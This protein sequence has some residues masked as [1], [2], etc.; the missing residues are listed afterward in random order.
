[1]LPQLAARVEE[2]LTGAYSALLQQLHERFPSD[3]QLDSFAIVYSEYFA[4]AFDT[5]D[6]DKR[7]DTVIELYGVERKTASSAKLSPV[8]NAGRLRDQKASFVKA[9]QSACP[10][11]PVAHVRQ[12]GDETGP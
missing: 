9:M 10:G 12:G 2:D 8:L 11:P 3:E 1:M 7:L 6:F 5:K 4:S